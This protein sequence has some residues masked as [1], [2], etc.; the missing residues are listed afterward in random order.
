[1]KFGMLTYLSVNARV[2]MMKKEI[3]ENDPNSG[4]YTI[5]G[6]KLEPSEKG[7]HKP[8]GRSE[9][10]VREFKEETGLTLVNPTFRG[11][12]LF[13]NFERIFD[14]WSNPEDFLVY[15]YSATQYAGQLGKGKDNEVPLWVNEKDIPSLPK[16]IGDELIYQWLND[17]RFF[18]GIIKHK[19]KVLD[20]EGTY[21][22]FF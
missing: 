4:K 3:R 13:H 10:T 15:V 17:S 5:P 7:M 11:V 1:M 22:D 9:A 19:G 8:A 14:N 2:L 16:N 6:G 18:I 20:E 21:V 12:I